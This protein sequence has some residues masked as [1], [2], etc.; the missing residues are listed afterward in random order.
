MLAK[1]NE[2][3]LELTD[4]SELEAEV[5]QADETQDKINLAIL[6]LLKMHSC[7]T[8]PWVEGR[9]DLQKACAEQAPV[10]P[11]SVERKIILSLLH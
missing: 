9:K 11:S 4:E 1:L 8:A 3:I 7:L 10:Y 5:E 6:R 2:D